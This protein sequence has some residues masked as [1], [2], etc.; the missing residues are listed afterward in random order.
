MDTPTN[1]YKIK[2]GANCT[3][4][5]VGFSTRGLKLEG[6]NYMNRGYYFFCNGGTLY[7]QDG[8]QAVARISAIQLK[9]SMKMDILN[10]H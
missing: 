10:S 4:L 2:L 1:H 9:Q 5:M 7:S 8:K 6:E 3:N